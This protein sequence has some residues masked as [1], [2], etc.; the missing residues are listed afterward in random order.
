MHDYPHRYDSR[1]GRHFVETTGELRI[2]FSFEARKHAALYLRIGDT[3]VATH[4]CAGNLSAKIAEARKLLESFSCDAGV[5]R[6]V[7]D[8]AIVRKTGK[9]DELLRHAEEQEK[10]AQF[11][12]SLEL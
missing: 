12:C 9:R 3:P 10:H 11:L 5:L 2:Q 4:Y 6:D 8:S 1:R 7:V